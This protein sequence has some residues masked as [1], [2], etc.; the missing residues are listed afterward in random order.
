[1][2][3]GFIHGVMNTDN[4]TISGETIDYGPCAFMDVEDPATVFSSIDHGGRYAYGNQPRIAQWNLARLAESLLPLIDADVDAAIPVATDELQRF[5][6]RFDAHWIEACAARRCVGDGDADGDVVVRGVP[7]LLHA[8]RVDHTRFYRSLS[9]VLRGDAEP[10]RSL[11][12]D[13]DAFD[14][15]A[16]R[17][18]PLVAADAE[19]L[20]R[21]NP[22]Y[23]ARNHLVE[24]A[25]A[26]A[27]EGDMAPFDALL[28]VLERPFDERPGLNGTRSVRPLRAAD[29]LRHGVPSPTVRSPISSSLGADRRSG[30]ALIVWSVALTR[31][32]TWTL[33][34][35]P[36][37]GRRR[38]GRA[39]RRHETLAVVGLGHTSRV[40]D[41][42]VS[43]AAPLAD[44]GDPIEFARRR[45]DRRG[46]VQRSASPVGAR[47]SDRDPSPRTQCGV[48]ADRTTE[49]GRRPRDHGDGR[50]RRRIRLNCCRVIPSS[51]PWRPPAGRVV[52][53]L[54]AQPDAR[55][56]APGAAAAGEAR[57]R[58]LAVARV[59]D[60]SART[61]DHR[62]RS[63]S[64]RCPRRRPRRGWLSGGCAKICARWRRCSATPGRS[65]CELAWLAATGPS[66]PPRRAGRPRDWLPR[67]RRRGRLSL[68]RATNTLAARKRCNALASPRYQ[69]L[70]RE[71][72]AAPPTGNVACMAAT[73]DCHLLPSAHR[74]RRDVCRLDDRAS[75][76]A[77]TAHGAKAA[78]YTAELLHPWSMR[79]DELVEQMHAVQDVL[80]RAG[81]GRGNDWSIV[82]AHQWPQSGPARLIRSAWPTSAGRGLTRGRGRNRPRKL[83]DLDRRRLPSRAHDKWWGQIYGRR[84]AGARAGRR[85]GNAHAALLHGDRGWTTPAEAGCT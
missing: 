41:R 33:R 66:T 12:A 79:L 17:W 6:E 54:G 60:H 37:P 75:P 30:E 16:A 62:P 64:T 81:H 52:A 18:R 85:E 65:P 59:T 69:A 10:A 38:A 56:S 3:V 45:C 32:S 5:T 21:V 84:R 71:L 63:A 27:T 19:A 26:A 48:V 76:I 39:T 1:M 51:T 24:E 82:P 22:V 36:A 40:T 35:V 11:F 43:L 44:T 72:R 46:I 78:R 80:G 23:I 57:R 67:R 8:Q 55:R 73:L 4:T 42:P 68:R 25:L 7:D 70:V 13:P 50:R 47:W 49:V 20:D 28:A 2:H 83:T 9:A 34:W 29:V 15:W 53:L 58:Y 74:V 61:A 31:R 14:R 77:A